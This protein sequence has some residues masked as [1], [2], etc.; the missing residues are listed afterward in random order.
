MKFRG[1]KTLAKISKFTVIKMYFNPWR[2]FLLYYAVTFHLG[3][4]SFLKYLY[5]NALPHLFSVKNKHMCYQQQISLIPVQPQCSSDE[6]RK[7]D[8]HNQYIATCSHTKFHQDN[9]YRL[10]HVILVL[11]TYESSKCWDDP[12]Q[13]LSLVKAFTACTHKVGKWVKVYSKLQTSSPTR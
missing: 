11:I 9:I 8:V 1:N 2:L 6:K 13:M 5:T 3:L 12:A 4:C 7:T 10:T